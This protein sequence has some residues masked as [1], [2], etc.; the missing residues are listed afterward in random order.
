ML[1]DKTQRFRTDPRRCPAAHC[2][3]PENQNNMEEEALHRIPRELRQL[4][5]LRNETE[6]LDQRGHISRVHWK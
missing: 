2:Q 4:G 6:N 3:E 5:Q 1:R